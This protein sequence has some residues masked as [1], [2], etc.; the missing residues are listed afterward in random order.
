MVPDGPSGES[1]LAAGGHDKLRQVDGAVFQGQGVRVADG[2]DH[3]AA[4]GP[5]AGGRHGDVTAGGG[6]GQQITAVLLLRNAA[7]AGGQRI[8][9]VHGDVIAV[10]TGGC[11]GHG[12]AGQH[13]VTG[14]VDIEVVKIAA[15]A[16]GGH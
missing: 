11:D 10:H 13:I 9:G 4:L 14:G 5:P 2:M 16:V 12:T 8:A 3:G 6:G 1:G 7:G 15:G